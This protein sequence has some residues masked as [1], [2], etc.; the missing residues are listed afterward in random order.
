[1]IYGRV[2]YM[3]NEDL[4]IYGS[5]FKNMTT[6]PSNGLNRQLDGMGYAIGMEY[7]MSKRSFL[8]VQI[9]RS[10]GYNPFSPYCYGSGYG[11]YGFGA[12][13]FSYFP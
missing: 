9:Q 11:S 5:V 13:P 10:T 1:M 8:Q 2:D 3:V 6:I 12:R 7:K 4:L